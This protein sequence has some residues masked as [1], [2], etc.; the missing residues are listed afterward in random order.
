MLRILSGSFRNFLSIGNV[1]QDL[2]LMIDGLTLILGENMDVGGVNSRNG[3]GKTAILQ[4]VSY[5]LFGKPLTKIRLDNLTNS[6]NNKAM[7]V[8]LDLESN[9]R[10]YRIERGR[11]PTVLRFF[12]DNIAVDE[13]QGE[14]RHTQTEIERV[15]G[16]SYQMFRHIVALS[17]STIPFLREEASVQREVIEELF[18]QGDP[19]YWR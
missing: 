15:L 19:G 5:A 12:Q 18:G 9:G 11:K 10:R 17:T 6:I 8:T 4:A 7:L 14:S 2:D 1:T 16:M 3:A 13:A